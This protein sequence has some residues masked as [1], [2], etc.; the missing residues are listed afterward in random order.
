MEMLLSEA[1]EI[2]K[3]VNSLGMPLSYLTKKFFGSKEER[4]KIRLEEERKQDE[5]QVSACFEIQMNKQS[6]S[7][8]D[9]MPEGSTETPQR[10]KKRRK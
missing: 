2:N 6:P 4:E 7:V 5:D 1:K 8:L 9:I 3:K 10:P